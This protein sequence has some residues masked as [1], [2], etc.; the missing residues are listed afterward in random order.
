MLFKVHRA[1]CNAF[2]DRCTAKMPPRFRIKVNVP[3]LNSLRQTPNALICCCSTFFHDGSISPLNVFPGES[4]TSAWSG[5]GLEEDAH[6]RPA[7]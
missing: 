2:W 6:P 4:V 1:H 5:R 3:W 7:V